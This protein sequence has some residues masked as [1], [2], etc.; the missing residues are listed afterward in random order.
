[1]DDFDG[2]ERYFVV[3][4]LPFVE[5]NLPTAVFKENCITPEKYNKR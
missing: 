1:M 5:N 2:K 4:I 3:Y